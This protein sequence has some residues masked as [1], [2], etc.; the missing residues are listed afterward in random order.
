MTWVIFSG[1]TAESFV[2]RP[3]IGP[4]PTDYGLSKYDLLQIELA[5]KLNIP[6][7]NVDI[8]TVMNHPTL[9]K[10]VDIRYSAHGSPYY[11]P[12]RLDGILLNS[13]KEVGYDCSTQVYAFA[14][15]HMRV[16]SLWGN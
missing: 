1:T 2:G 3:K 7:E 12:A 9:V 15:C 10:T 4:S 6:L 11:R 5:K 13:K 16:F 14:I 8:F